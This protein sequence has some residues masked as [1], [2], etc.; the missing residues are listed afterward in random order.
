[1]PGNAH[2]RVHGADRGDERRALLVCGAG[3]FRAGDLGKT[4]ELFLRRCAVILQN[5]G[6]N[7]SVCQSVRRIIQPAERMG[8]RMDVADAR[9]GEGDACL[10]RSKQHFLPRFKIVSVHI[11]PFQIPE[12]R[13][14]RLFRAAV[15]LLRC[16]VDADVCLHRVRKRVHAGLRR[17]R[18][19]KV[20]GEHGVEHS[21]A[22]HEAEIH[23]G[24][25]VVRFFVG[26]NGGDRRLR[27][28]TGR[29]RHGDE[30]RESVHDLEKPRHLLHGTVGAHD[31]RRGSLGRVHRRAAAHGKETV[32]ALG[33]I[34]FPHLLDDG[35]C[36]IGAHAVKVDGG[37]ACRFDLRA[38]R[39]DE[40]RARMFAGDDHHLFHAAAAQQLRDLRRAARAADDLRLAPG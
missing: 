33:E 38:D 25:L 12:D 32:A 20:L 24:V 28:G 27:A 14:R 31:A 22:R 39:R 21:E 17:C 4:G 37:N 9:A 2:A 40:H 16:A 5:D 10:E 8:N 36:G 29:C 1:M 18:R 13:R 3:R 6:E 26:D 15:G 30:R 23:D 34:P 35:D 7:D 11:C 19:R